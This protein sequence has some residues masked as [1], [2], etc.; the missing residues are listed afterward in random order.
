MFDVVDEFIIAQPLQ[1]VVPVEAGEVLVHQVDSAVNDLLHDIT[2][3][4][5]FLELF[6]VVVLKCV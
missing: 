6:Q 1:G 5:E 3:G 4:A 2:D